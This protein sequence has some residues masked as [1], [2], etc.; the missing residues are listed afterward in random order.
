VLGSIPSVAA[1]ADSLT[2]RDLSGNVTANYFVGNGSQLTGMYSNTN[3]E[4]YLPTYTGNLAALTGNVTTTANVSANYVLGNGSQ[5]ASVN[6]VSVLGSV[7][8]VAANVDSLVQRDSN[9]NVTANYFVGNG[10]QLTGMYSNTNV[11]AYLPTYTGNLAALTGNVTTTANV[12]GNFFI[13]NGSQLTGL[14]EGYANS[15]VEAYLPTYTGN[16][17]ALTGNVTTTANISGSFLLGNGAFISGLP[18]N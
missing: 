18:A 7:P 12:S 5:L 17:A 3:V 14:P 2:L 1:N 11:E 4:A 8:S 15:K 13:G 10:S 16:L 9:G 6:A